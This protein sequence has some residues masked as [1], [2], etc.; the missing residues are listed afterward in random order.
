MFQRQFW[1]LSCWVFPAA[2]ALNNKDISYLTKY[3]VSKNGSY[4]AG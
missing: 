2:A 3:D 1:S 4:R